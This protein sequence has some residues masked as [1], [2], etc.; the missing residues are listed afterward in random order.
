MTIITA[1]F[2]T[3]LLTVWWCTQ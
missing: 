1:L 3:D 2:Q